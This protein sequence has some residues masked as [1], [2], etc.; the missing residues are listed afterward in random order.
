MIQLRLFNADDPK[1]ALLES[2]EFQGG[3]LT[4]GRG[5]DMNWSLRDPAKTISREHCI[6][7]NRG[8]DIFVI[9]KSSGGVFV[10][11]ESE[12]LGKDCERQ[13]SAGDR[14]RI[15]PY[16][17]HVVDQ[18]P[19]RKSRITG[20]SE[21]DFGIF[22]AADSGPAPAPVDIVV[23]DGP[24]FIGK[25]RGSAEPLPGSLAGTDE[26]NDKDGWG[27]TDDWSMGDTPSSTAE[28]WTPKTER[29]A[30]GLSRLLDDA[31]QAPRIDIPTDWDAPD[32][33][34]QKLLNSLMPRQGGDS[35]PS[36]A[37][38]AYKAFLE[39][40]NLSEADFA[41]CD[42]QEVMRRAGAAYR[43]AILGFS[44]V[45]KDRAVA[46]NELRL[47]RTV[48]RARENNPMK[49]LP[50]QQASVLLLNPGQSGFLGAEEA[51]HSACQ[52][53]KRHQACLI[54][55]M[56][57]V[58][59]AILQEIRPA[60]IEDE[61]DTLPRFSVIAGGG[62]DAMS[63]KQ[64]QVFYTRFSAEA[65]DNRNSLVYVEFRKGYESQ[66]QALQDESGKE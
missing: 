52:D 55:G 26:W 47:N 8:S 56:Q 60:R 11:T 37:G 14:L 17:L 7:Y 54:S 40:A 31:M 5:A 16:I 61:V 32:P 38:D 46:K 34:A 27:D 58:V 64:Y 19:A 21:P 18:P 15:G 10:N 50:P 44:E 23:P 2:R 59:R 62:R 39:G 4:I 3:R 29:R 22:G 65:I 28:D 36:A 20:G 13:L 42:P 25:P 33:G 41:G 66:D 48:M 6:L 9:D 12:K 45:L 30:D 63:W 1:Q 24:S 53:L 57:T 43:Q 35:A 51:F 49:F